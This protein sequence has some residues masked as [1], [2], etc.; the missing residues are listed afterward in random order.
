[1]AHP[2]KIFHLDIVG[3]DSALAHSA[4]WNLFLT[5]LELQIKCDESDQLPSLPALRELVLKVDPPKTV[6][7]TFLDSLGRLPNLRCLDISDMKWD[8]KML[9]QPFSSSL[10]RL[11]LG[12]TFAHEKIL[13]K[14][15]ENSFHSLRELHCRKS[16]FNKVDCFKNFISKFDKLHLFLNTVTIEEL[17][18]LTSSVKILSISSEIPDCSTNAL[19][20]SK[21]LR[22]IS[23]DFVNVDGV[24]GDNSNPFFSTLITAIKNKKSQTLKGIMFRH[25]AYWRKSIELKQVCE[26]NGIEVLYG[27][28]QKGMYVNPIWKHWVN[29]QIGIIGEFQL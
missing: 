16:S 18:L 4:F 14:A 24:D 11:K 22:Y 19:V 21:A 28:L 20:V 7:V 26:E 10:Q 2:P 3:L 17:G 29:E 5:H 23:I 1:V 9:S 25:N 13:V 12:I 27:N 8:D 15:F 6:T